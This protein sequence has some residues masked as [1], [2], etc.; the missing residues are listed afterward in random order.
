MGGV[1]SPRLLLKGISM[2]ILGMDLE[3]TGLS[4]ELDKITELGAVLWDTDRKKPVRIYSTFVWHKEKPPIT[5]EI[6]DLTGIT[7]EDLALYGISFY[8]A[9]QQF[10]LMVQQ[11]DYIVAHNG[12]MFDKPMLEAHCS[13][14]DLPL[15]VKPW[16]DTSKDIPY[17]EK[18][19]T[20]RLSYLATEHNF[21]NP[22]PHR[23]VFDVLTMLK[24]LSCYS[25]ED[26]I[27][28]SQMKDITL[29]AEVSYALKDLAK[30]KGF[31][32]QAEKKMWLKTVKQ[33][34]VA[35]FLEQCKFRVNI[36]EE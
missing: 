26:V 11:A 25:I 1:L 16:L 9:Y 21:L 32:W 33:D 18:I 5:K 13:G 28:Y 8:D 31:Y 17:P 12:A 7:E 27:S 22:F 2:L 15:P 14:Y 6:E 34:R 24:V 19:T 36:Y 20:R 4:M 23:A 3:T 10:D 29:Q 35:K 30:E